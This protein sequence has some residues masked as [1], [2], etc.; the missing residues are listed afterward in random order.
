MKI[1]WQWCRMSR[2]SVWRVTFCA[3]SFTCSLSNRPLIIQ[4]GSE[5]CTGWLSPITIIVAG[6]WLSPVTSHHRHCCH[7]WHHYGGVG[8]GVGLV[9]SIVVFCSNYCH[10]H[11]HCLCYHCHA[12]QC[13]LHVHHL[14]I[15]R[16]YFVPVRLCFFDDKIL[17]FVAASFLLFSYQP[18]V[19]FRSSSSSLFVFVL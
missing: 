11:L 15:N 5:Q 17:C 14:M 4:V 1:M 12:C 9:V 16:S 6:D 19:S 7:C 2:W 10:H 3:M 18:S 13:F 8:V